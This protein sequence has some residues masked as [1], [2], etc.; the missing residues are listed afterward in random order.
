[1]YLH[2]KKFFIFETVLSGQL[3]EIMKG[4]NGLTFDDN[5]ERV[6]P[7]VEP[8]SGLFQAANVTGFT[9]SRKSDPQSW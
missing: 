4:A 8:V 7:P 1:V 9:R 5:Q 2:L 6:M 3:H